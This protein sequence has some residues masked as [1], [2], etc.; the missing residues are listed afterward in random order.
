MSKPIPL[1]V[2]TY[3]AQQCNSLFTVI[4]EQA[5]NECSKELLDLISIACDLNE[6][7]WQSLAEATK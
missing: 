4:L 5:S 1:D 6:E 7:I 2:A 3:K